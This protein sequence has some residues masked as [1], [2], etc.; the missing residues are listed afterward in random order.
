MPDK[1]Q[2]LTTENLNE[3][4]HSTGYLLPRTPLELARFELLHKGLSHS[5]DYKKI[6]PLAIISG[7][8][9]MRHIISEDSEDVSGTI[10]EL[11]MA[12]RKHSALPDDIIRKIKNNHLKKNGSDSPDGK[13]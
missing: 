1:I 2:I 12:A 6:D 9:K 10:D 5:V 8:W 11:R 7:D 13:E 3:W 4:M